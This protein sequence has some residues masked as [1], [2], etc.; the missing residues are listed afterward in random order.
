MCWKV[1]RDAIGVVDQT[2]RIRIHHPATPVIGSTSP[3]A[4]E[5]A[6][7]NIAGSVVNP[8]IREGIAGT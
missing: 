8:L 3:E 7:G 1:N 2:D 5:N 4:A 6:R